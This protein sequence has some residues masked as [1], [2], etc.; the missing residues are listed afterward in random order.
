M[1]QTQGRENG[2]AL[3]ERTEQ[4]ASR[5][6][7]RLG[8]LAGRTGL[9]IQQVVRAV[10]E[11]ADRRDE[12]AEHQRLASKVGRPANERQTPTAR[13]EEVVD[14]LGQEIGRRA[15][16]KGLQAKRALARLRE[17][18]ED[19]WVEARDMRASWRGTQRRP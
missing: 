2:P 6:G 14:R 1:T 11:E 19:L 16:V 17:E 3:I 13:A 9:R 12:S 4:A 15:L 5:A 7:E 10:H 8:R 18:A